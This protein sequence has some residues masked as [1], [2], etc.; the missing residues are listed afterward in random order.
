[1]KIYNVFLTVA[2]YQVR[3]WH[4][5]TLGL[6]N[7][8]ELLV[9]PVLLHNGGNW[10]HALP[11]GQKQNLTIVT[12]EYYPVV[13]MNFNPG[14]KWPKLII[15][16]TYTVQLSLTHIQLQI[17]VW[18]ATIK[19]SHKDT[20]KKSQTLSVRFTQTQPQLHTLAQNLNSK[21]IL[22]LGSMV[23]SPLLSGCVIFY[24]WTKLSRKVMGWRD[25]SVTRTFWMAGLLSGKSVWPKILDSRFVHT[26]LPLWV[27]ASQITSSFCR[28][29]TGRGLRI[30]IR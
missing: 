6:T 10:T 3:V 9:P 28:S 17:C 18:K 21:T 29:R 5:S 22:N 19:S 13:P 30:T 11:A 2:G 24:A 26:R 27:W 4:D 8:T 12:C 20:V 7:I 14:L 23:D 1:V 15:I 25:S 16:V